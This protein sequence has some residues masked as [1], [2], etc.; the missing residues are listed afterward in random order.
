MLSL[1]RN[2]AAPARSEIEL[3]RLISRRDFSTLKCAA[4]VI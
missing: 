1:Y 3:R 4:Q 2:A